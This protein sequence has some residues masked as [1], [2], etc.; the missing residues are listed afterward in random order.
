MVEIVGINQKLAKIDLKKF[1]IH[2]LN[3]SKNDKKNKIISVLF[4]F[5]NKKFKTSG[6]IVNIQ[7][8]L[9]IIFNIIEK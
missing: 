5:D 6:E 1:H 2:L 9:K 3:I 8:D 4:N 7:A